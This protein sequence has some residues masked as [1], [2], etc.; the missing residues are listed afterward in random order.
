VYIHTGVVYAMR[1]DDEI[2]AHAA[3]ENPES[4][5]NGREISAVTNKNKERDL[6]A[7]LPSSDDD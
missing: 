6:I 3:V 4:C 5:R 1:H 2:L 7:S